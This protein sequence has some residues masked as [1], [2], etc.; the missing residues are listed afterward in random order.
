VISIPMMRVLDISEAPALLTQYAADP[1]QEPVI[2]TVKGKPVAVVLPAEGGDV[3]SISVSLNPQFTEL[4][5]RSRRSSEGKKTYSSEELRREFGLPPFG[6]RKPKA[7]RAK[8]KTPS[9]KR[10]GEKDGR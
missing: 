10:N 4:I 3:E 1:N 9:R 8:K 5:E 7:R 6:E 2:L